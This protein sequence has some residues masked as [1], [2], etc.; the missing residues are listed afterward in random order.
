MASIVQRGNRYNVVYLYNAEDGKRKQKWESFKT[1]AEA[2]R[3]K[4]EVEYRQQIGSMVVPTCKTLEDLLKEYVALYGK[5]TWS[6]SMYSSTIAL[7]ENYITPFIGS[8][9]LSDITA[10]VLEKYYMQLMTTPAA[11]KATDKKYAK[12][13]DYV[14][15]GTVKRIHNVLRSAFHQAVKWELMEKNPAIYATVPKPEVHK[16]DIWDAETLFRALEVCEDDRLKLAI[17]LAFA[18]SMRIGEILGLTWD[19]IDI[20]PE[21]IKAG[22]AFVYI[23]KELQRVD[24]SALDALEKKDVL[25]V[26]PDMKENNKTVLILKKPKTTSSI[27]KVFLPRTVAEMLVKWKLNQ[28]F[29]K[30]SVGKEYIDYNLVVANSLGTP[31]E[32]SRITSLFKELIETHD[33]PK[34]VFHSLRHSSITYKLKLNGGDIKSVQ[35]DSGHAVASM[36]T[37]Q[38]SH[39]LDDDRKSNAARLEEAFYSGKDL[40]PDVQRN[41]PDAESADPSDASDAPG[42]NQELLLKILANPEMANLLTALAKSLK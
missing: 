42:I 7:I 2:K 21:S 23:N 29:T 1:L 10:R 34:V 32:H 15:A 27:R 33:L 20:T 8:M 4:S 40:N 41:T 12:K 26:F 35:G 14:T 39:I 13:R 38:Y 3:R 25:R 28:D 37:D 5:N 19:C 30:E 31:I 18:C 24:K 22:K 36:V 11:R 9:K 6:I 17:N 16:R